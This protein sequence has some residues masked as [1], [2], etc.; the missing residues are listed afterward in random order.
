MPADHT[1]TICGIL[2]WRIIHL[3]LTAGTRRTCI[4]FVRVYICSYACYSPLYVHPSIYVSLDRALPCVCPYPLWGRGL[5]LYNNIV[6]HVRP[7]ISAK[8]PPPVIVG[9]IRP[10]QSCFI[11]LIQDCTL[12]ISITHSSFGTHWPGPLVVVPFATEVGPLDNTIDLQCYQS[13]NSLL[14]HLF[15]NWNCPTIIPSLVEVAPWL[16][17]LRS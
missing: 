11:K 12:N 15:N 10:P 17:G 13:I 14:V 3:P 7:Q 5:L 16:R 1:K 6:L 4:S 9:L 8:L 2:F